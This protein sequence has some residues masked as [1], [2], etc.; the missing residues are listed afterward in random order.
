MFHKAD[1]NGGSY[2]FPAFLLLTAYHS[3]LTTHRS[4]LTTHRSLLTTHHSPLATHRP[5]LTTTTGDE[6]IDLNEFVHMQWHAGGLDVQSQRSQ[7]THS[8]SQPS[9]KLGRQ[10]VRQSGSQAVSS[11]SSRCL[12]LAPYD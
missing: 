11:A 10:A 5:P 3:P 9:R 4:L 2:L 1:L 6:F 12:L 8:V 7:V